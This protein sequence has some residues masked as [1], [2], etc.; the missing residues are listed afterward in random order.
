MATIDKSQADVLNIVSKYTT[1]TRKASTNGGEYSGACPMCGGNDRFSVWPHRH[2]PNANIYYCRNCG[3][4][5][6]IK[7]V[8]QAEKCTFIQACEICG[9]ALE[10]DSAPQKEQR[11]RLSL[12]GEP[13]EQWQESAIALIQNSEDYLWSG[14]AE[15]VI[16]YLESRGLSRR[17][18]EQA[19]IGY[20]PSNTFCSKEAW[21]IDDESI[22]AVFLPRGILIPWLID[23]KPYKLNVRRFQ[24]DM[25]EDEQQ[26]R[27]PRKY[28]DIKGGSR[29]MYR[30]DTIQKGKPVFICEGEFDALIL[31]QEIGGY[32]SVVATGSTDRGRSDE[33]I[34]QLVKASH[35]I[36]A[37][38]NDEAAQEAIKKYWLRVFPNAVVWKPTAKDINEMHIKNANVLLWAKRAM[39]LAGY[40]IPTHFIT[41]GNVITC[42]AD[43]IRYR[44]TYSISDSLMQEDKHFM[45]NMMD[46]WKKLAHYTAGAVEKEYTRYDEK[47]GAF[48]KTQIL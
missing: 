46:E 16:A 4:G 44:V 8:M 31:M 3:G 42:N 20:I 24:E 11:P 18:I 28:I 30:I 39:L 6:I 40:D 34:P 5:D 17:T 27:K 33:W 29:G 15:H 2:D 48:T 7:L 43:T 10:R 32:A 26:G 1:V 47:V 13:S 14:K 37:F 12:D 19:K 38:D 9:I 35:M 25:D 22:K 23:G 21:G 41:W 36:L 45:W